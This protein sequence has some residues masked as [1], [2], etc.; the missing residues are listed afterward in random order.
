MAGKIRL[1]RIQAEKL[2][3]ILIVT[4]F[5]KNNQ[6]VT[7]RALADSGTAKSLVAN[8][9]IRNLPKE[10]TKKT[11]WSTVA[12]KF[13]TNGKASAK[14]KLAELNPTAEIEHK[15]HV[16]STLGRYD[17][18]IG[19]DLLKTMGLIIDFENKLISWVK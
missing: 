18:I 12:G 6:S 9:F 11:S 3:P 4:L 1:K 15:F 13:Q 8:K 14:F 10:K 19:R 16:M 2:V 7:I 17:M 5:N